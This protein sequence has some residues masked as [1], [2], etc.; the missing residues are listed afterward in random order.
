[1]QRGMLHEPIQKMFY[2]LV[3]RPQSHKN[4]YTDVDSSRNLIEFIHLLIKTVLVKYQRMSRV[5]GKK[6]MNFA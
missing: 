5:Q 4:L 1:M 3:D 6:T 2:L